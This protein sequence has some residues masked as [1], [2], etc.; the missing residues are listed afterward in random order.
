MSEV[1]V[2]QVRAIDAWGNKRIIHAYESEE[3][4][5]TAI[6]IMRRRAPARYDIKAVPNQPNQYW[7]INFPSTIPTKPTARRNA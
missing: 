2:Y 4:A 1:I 7:G 6:Q 3:A 5:K